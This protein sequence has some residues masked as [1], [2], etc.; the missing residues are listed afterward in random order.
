M[1]N[2]HFKRSVE[3][4]LKVIGGKWK[5]VILCH[6]TAF[7]EKSP[8]SLRPLFVMSVNSRGTT[9]HFRTTK[10]LLLGGQK[11]LIDFI[12]CLS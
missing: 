12:G 7:R 1:G 10:S 5:L 2:L 11:G 6:L 4:T 3:K 9:I 8:S